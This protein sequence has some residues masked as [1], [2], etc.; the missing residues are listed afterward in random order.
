MIAFKCKICGGNLEL[1]N[2]A[3]I[4]T[5]SSCGSTHSLPNLENDKVRNL[6]ERANQLRLNHQFDK[7]MG[8]YETIITEHPHDPETYWSLVLCRYGVEYVEDPKTNKRM[9]TT[10]RTLPQSVLRDADYQQAIK[11]ASSDTKRFYQEEAN[12]IDSIQKGILS[13]S[14]QEDPYDIFICYKETDDKGKRTIDSVLGQKL[15][16]EL[17]EEGFKVFFAKITLEDKLGQ[18]YEPY[19]YS[20]LTTS[21]VMLVLGTQSKYFEA[22]WVRNEWSRF[23]TMMKSD[24]KKTLIPLYRDMDAYGLPEEFRIFQSQDLNKVGATQDLIRGLKKLIPLEKTSTNIVQKQSS[25]PKDRNLSTKIKRAMI[26]LEDADFTAATNFAEEALDLDPELAEAYLVK[27]LAELEVKSIDDL[28]EIKDASEIQDYQNNPR[29]YKKYLEGLIDEGNAYYQKVKKFGKKTILPLIEASI[30]KNKLKILSGVIENIETALIRGGSSPEDFQVALDAI[31]PKLSF[32]H[33]HPKGQALLKKVT[34]AKEHLLVEFALLKARGLYEANPEDLE[35]ALKPLKNYLA[36]QQ[37]QKLMEDLTSQHRQYVQDKAVLEL[38]RKKR[39][40]Q[41]I[42]SN[43]KIE[44]V[45]NYQTALHLIQDI[46]GY[47]DVD[48]LQTFAAKKLKDLKQIQNKK[49][50]KFSLFTLVG[51]ILLS[52]TSISVDRFVLR[53]YEVQFNANG[54]NPIESDFL[55]FGQAI[56]EPNILPYKEGHSFAGWYIDSELTKPFDFGSMPANDVTVYAK[57]SIN[58][59]TIS[60]QSNGGTSIISITQDYGTSVGAPTPP[61]KTGYTFM[62]W[63]RD[64]AFNIGYTFTTM[65]AESPILY[66]KWSINQYQLN[67]ITNGG[68][69]MNPQLIPYNQTITLSN[70]TRTGYTFAGWY[71]D[72]GLTEAFNL[73]QMP[74][75]DL[76]VYA[77]W[78]INQYTISFSTNGGTS[79][80]SITQDYG[81]S[82]NTPTPPT[83]IE[84]TFIGWYRDEA[85]NTGYS[86]TTMPAENLTLYAKWSPNQ[87]QVNFVTNGGQSMNPQMIGYEQLITLANP[88]RT[89]YTF[90]GWYQDSGLTEAFN[91]TQ[92]P[93]NGITVYAKWIINQYT[94]SFSTNGGTSVNSITLDYGTS[95]SLANISSTKVGYN[96]AGWFSNVGLTESAPITMP[97]QNLTFYAKWTIIMEKLSIGTSYSSALNS[98]GR[99]FMWGRNNYGQ[100]GDGTTTN[101]NVPTEITSRFLLDAGDKIISLTLGT[102]DT[103]ALSATGRVYMWGLNYGGKLGDGTSTNRNVPTEITSRFS[104]DA[105]DKII[106]LSLSAYSSSAVS[107]TGR[108]FMWGR[109]EYGQLGDGTTT[110]RNVPT[111]ITSRFSLSAGDKIISLS[112]GSNHTSAL[113]ATG[114][115]HMWGYN[116]NGQLGDDTTTHRN[117]PTEMTSRFSLDA[118]DK[119]ISLSLG[120]DTSSALSSTGRVYMWGKNLSSLLGAGSDSN[121]IKIPTEITS[122]FS[123]AAG[124]KIISLSLGSSSS[125]F[126]ALSKTGRVF[127][128]G[129]NWAGQLGDGTMTSRYG[130]TEITSR[131]SLAAG[132]KII[133][134]SLGSPHTSALSE[135]GRVFMWGRNDYGQL[136]DGTTTHINTPLVINNVMELT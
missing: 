16:E 85:F 39:I 2:V 97:A 23:L 72:S 116:N 65:P 130:P 49:I 27:W 89:G 71:Q 52:I 29:E 24:K 59:Y 118:G 104:L 14:N 36:H 70:P 122:R 109:N 10:H 9:I 92:M 126:S 115:V 87:Y 99:V 17:I 132:D 15:Y 83:K 62:G 86:F 3:K 82:V 56:S 73:T 51:M 84:Y 55:N 5:C 124:D 45:K 37:V 34:E 22:P 96:F 102:T 91:L 111:E 131:F 43:L 8:I 30:Q 11:I 129:D 33:D 28:F 112:L 78:S 88:I 46:Q 47:E 134:L 44:K 120:D 53:R 1:E 19:I 93:A 57:W 136:G 74:A 127:M 58:Q 13:I 69:S 114:R 94:I 4:A 20:A 79:V 66:A 31:E 60:F 61:T 64:E 119:I 103:S 75:N 106:S 113:S 101:R 63:Y 67:F 41:D 121:Y 6:F 40:Y 76:T 128:W 21:K 38:E 42:Q 123:L 110:N 125:Y 25:E 98:T 26:A 7:A 68:Q 12:Q 117:I 108:V 105:G 100:L 32:I 90:V 81:T 77:K 133:S 18:E 135:T 35:G 50:L 48:S 107:S 54:G 95:I 80:N